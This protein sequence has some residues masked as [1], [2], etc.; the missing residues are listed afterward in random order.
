MLLASLIRPELVFPALPGGEWQVVLRTVS[1]LIAD[2]GLV[3]DADGLYR[4]LCEREE[5]GSTGFG[6]GTAIPHCK[7]KGLREVLVSVARCTETV[8]FET[9]DEEP[10]R[11][12]F[13]VVS[14]T[15]SPAEHLQALALISRWLKQEGH[16]GRILAIDDRDDMVRFLTRPVE[17]GS[18][19][20]AA[21]SGEEE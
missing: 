20:A 16:V 19:A 17:E 21:G 4:K 18:G 11:L 10:V 8:D 14:P 13:T 5:L 7:L 15:G 1:Q 3:R 2:Q 9:P 6:A 12:L